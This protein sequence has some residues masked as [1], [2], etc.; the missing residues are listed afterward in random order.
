M[1]LVD[2][3]SRRVIVEGVRQ[4][5]VVATD[6]IYRADPAAGARS[7]L[8]PA[9]ALVPLE[10]AVALGLVDDAEAEED[11]DP[12]SS[13]APAA[14]TGEPAEGPDTPGQSGEGPSRPDSE[15]EPEAKAVDSDGVEDKAVQKAPAAKTRPSRRK[16][17]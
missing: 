11:S 1:S 3:P 5:Y 10:E 6:R 7:L 2:F 8:Y 16:A 9:G 4:E 12:E 17:G 15:P 14:A 13:N